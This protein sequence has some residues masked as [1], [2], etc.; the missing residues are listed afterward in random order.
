MITEKD[1]ENLN[2]GIYILRY[3]VDSSIKEYGNP[4]P[5]MI[6]K[7]SDGSTWYCI[8]PSHFIKSYNLKY[9]IENLKSIEPKLI[10]E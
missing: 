8:T 2:F 4:I 7:D 5:V 6:G 9:L 10:M 1:I 3:H